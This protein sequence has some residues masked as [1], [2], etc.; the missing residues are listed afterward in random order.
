MFYHERWLKHSGVAHDENPPG[1]GSGRYS[2]GSG[3]NPY[4]HQKGFL[5]TVARMRESGLKDAEIAKAL[6]GEKAKVADLKATEAIE[7]KKSRQW[8]MTKAAQLLEE[9]GG[10]VSE[11]ARRM[12]KNESSIRSL[13]DPVIA[14]NTSRYENTA[15]AIKSR[16]DE[17]GIV[18]V[19]AYTEN[20]LGVTKHTKDVAI[21]MLE[22]EGYVKGYV[23]IPQLT[24]KNKTTVMV[25]AKPGTTQSEIQKKKFEI[26]TMVDYTPDGG[27]TWK[28]PEYPQSLDSNRVY[29]RYAEDGGVDKDGV[30]ELRRNVKDLSLGNSQYAQV[31]IMVDDDMYMKGMAMYADDV[32]EGY[33]VIY[34]TNKKRGTPKE[35]VFKPVKRIE[36]TGEI[37]KENPFGATIKSERY[38]EEKLIRAGGQSHYIDDNG[39]ERLSPINKIQDEG[40]W[41]SWSRNL[42]SQF[43]SKQPI[44]LINKQ[45]DLSIQG[46]K[47]DYQEITDLTNPV[48]KKKLLEDFA[49][50]CDANAASLSATGFKNLYE[51]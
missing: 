50:E 33:D 23:Q 48:L 26:E 44:N 30:V 4:Q 11:V 49:T 1:R 16:I 8:D 47:N 19:G 40:D 51:R 22:K 6:L 34:N 25:L 18:D 29:I 3:D 37:D 12:G 36:E 9:C 45:L 15:K 41:D 7:K 38:D 42:A 21:S 20:A 32:P 17:K 13:L 14:E 39:V 31:R 2:W 35:K 27:K 24:T 10:N 28:K 46:K 5:P 43:L